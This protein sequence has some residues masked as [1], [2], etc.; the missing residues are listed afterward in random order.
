[1]HIYVCLQAYIHIHIYECIYMFI[2][3]GYNFAEMLKTTHI[4]M[5]TKVF[6]MAKMVCNFNRKNR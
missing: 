5:S 3:L 1:M 2:A 4:T 6:N